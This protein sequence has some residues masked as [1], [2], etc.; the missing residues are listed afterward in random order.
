M[1]KAIEAGMGKGGYLP[2]QAKVLATAA[3]NAT[4]GRY[5]GKQLLKSAEDATEG[6]RLTDA[7]FRQ[8]AL[9]RIKVL[10]RGDDTM[11]GAATLAARDL[12]R[13]L[14]GNIMR[15]VPGLGKTLGTRGFQNFLLGNT[16]AQRALKKALA[17]QSGQE[18]RTVISGIRR[19]M[20]AQAGP[21]APPEAE[22]MIQSLRGN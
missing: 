3:R 14:T 8:E 19:A 5:T 17:T 20:A 13:Q 1:Q 10:P 18:V 6:G 9:D 4:E 21:N 15:L 12:V 16:N 22:Q 2:K 7:P 11:A